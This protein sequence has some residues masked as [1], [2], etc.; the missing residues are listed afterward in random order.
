M[1]RFALDLALPA[2]QYRSSCYESKCCKLNN[3]ELNI[4]IGIVVSQTCYVTLSLIA[5][6]I[7]CNIRAS[8]WK[9]STSTERKMQSRIIRNCISRWLSPINHFATRAISCKTRFLGSIF[10]QLV[11]LATGFKLRAAKVAAQ[12]I[13]EIVLIGMIEYNIFRFKHS[14]DLS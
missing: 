4:C 12:I 7:A 3:I 8:S 14:S 5:A 11:F 6:N 9:K 2:Q 1:H 13:V 10:R